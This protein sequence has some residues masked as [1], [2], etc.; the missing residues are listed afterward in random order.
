M[1]TTLS[2]GHVQA[3]SLISPSP[4]I[5]GARGPWEQP[6]GGL[7]L[8]GPRVSPLSREETG[9]GGC[10]AGTEPRLPWGQLA[11]SSSSVLDKEES[12][13]NVRNEL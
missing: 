10:S 1:K 4:E 5:P 8:A 13:S 12:G 3:S 9:Q 6:G 7:G 11:A 2:G